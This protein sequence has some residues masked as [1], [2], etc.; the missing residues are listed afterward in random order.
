MV[1]ASPPNSCTAPYA[2]PD[3]ASSASL[4]PVVLVWTSAYIE[5]R[6]AGCEGSKGCRGEP[7]VE[8]A[9][10]RSS[11]RVSIGAYLRIKGRRR[12]VLDQGGSS[13]YGV[14]AWLLPQRLTISKTGIAGYTAKPYYLK[15]RDSRLHCIVLLP[16]RQG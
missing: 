1:A 2:P 12:N 11:L 7:Y 8:L 16:Q 9:C 13:L 15:D 5:D 4:S 6:P 3:A 14:T 10:V